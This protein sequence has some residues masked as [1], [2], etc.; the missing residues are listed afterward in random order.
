MRKIFTLLTM[1]CLSIGA[2]WAQIYSP[3]ARTTT[4]EAGKKYFISA[5]TYYRN[6]RPNLLYNNKGNLAYSD[7]KPTGYYK[8]TYV[9][10]VEKIVDGT[11]FIKNSD[12][13]YLQSNSL[14]S[15]VDETGIIVV[16]YGKVKNVHSCG[17]DVDACDENGTFIDYNN[18]DE[19]TPIVCVYHTEKNGW[20]HINGLEI[21]TS[22][23]FAFYEAKEGIQLELTTDVNTPVYYTIKNMRGNAYAAYDGDT[24][25][26]KLLP[27][28]EGPDHLFYFTKGSTEG[29]YKIHTY[30]TDKKCAAYNSWTEDGIDWYI[31]ASGSSNYV[32]FAISKEAT[33]TAKG[34]EAWNDYE[35]AHT[36]INWY[37]GDDD[38][39]VWSIEKHQGVMPGLQ[40]STEGNIVLHYIRSNRRT[41]YVNFD[42]HNVK[43]K[44][45]NEGLNSY[46]YFVE[47]ETAT[48]VPEGYV[49]VKIFNAAHPTAVE[50]YT[51][52]YMEDASRSAKTFL[53]GLRQ[54]KDAYGTGY[55][56]VIYLPGDTK[57]WHD[58]NGTEVGA[59]GLGDRG[60][61]WRIYPANKTVDQLK[62][63]ANTAK[64]NALAFIANAEEADFY[65]YS[66]E[67]IAT[68][69]SAVE[70]MP[71]NKVHDAINVLKTV[72]DPINTLKAEKRS[73]TAPV[74][75]QY[76]LLKNKSKK[77][78]MTTMEDGNQVHRTSD[79]SEFK[80]LW[81]V[82]EG[83]NGVKLYNPAKDL[84]MGPLS[85]SAQVEMVSVE[86]AQEFVFTN[87]AEVYGVF[88]NVDGTQYT[89]AHMD[90]WY[91]RVVGWE[92]VSDASQWII[93][94]VTLEESLADLQEIYDVVD[95]AFGTEPGQ[96]KEMV[97][98]PSDKLSVAWANAKEVLEN[99]E[100]K[101]VYMM[102]ILAYDLK[103][104]WN[105]QLA[106]PDSREINPPVPGKFYRLKNVASGR[107]MNVKDASS[108]V[109]TDAGNNLPSTI[110]Y[111]GD[112]NTMLS[113][114]VGQ[115][116]D[117]QNK[118]LAAVGTPHNGEFAAA[119]S[120][121]KPNT[122]MYKNNSYWTYG[123]CDNNASI[124]RGS[125]KP[126]ANTVGY[127]WTLEKIETLPVTVSSVGVA[128]L[129]TPVAL[130]IP[131]DVNVY[132]AVKD[133]D[134][135][136][137]YLKLQLI[138]TGYI[139]A[140]TGV[141]LE[142]NNADTYYF[143]VTDEPVD[144][145]SSEKNVLTG[146][147]ET[148]YM[149]TDVKVYT[150]QKPTGKDLGFYLFKGTKPITGF[151]SWL[152]LPKDSQVQ[153]FRFKFGTT[154]DIESLVT[155]Q[156]AKAIYDLSGRRVENMDKGIYIVNGK[157]IVVK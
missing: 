57:G 68:A 103:A 13:K 29:T 1:L 85:K 81:Q 141:I 124:N 62:N 88:Q 113:Y 98:S 19:N 75:G 14:A 5:A 132:T 8:S 123:N 61:L 125:N 116:L 100:A 92:A 118:N 51:T 31:I 6:A 67:A 74:A 12:G 48:N 115:Y 47:D 150:L 153:S 37:G 142:A 64:T 109:V 71:I 58:F 28:V 72:N 59:Y 73:T 87:Q 22:T 79:A 42:G 139:P 151:R 60:S 102:S 146:K 83:E 9:F 32:G 30:G 131:A 33:L 120:G 41:T 4:L 144:G 84:Y 157:K 152:E 25:T 77:Q 66:D 89:F 49:A 145:F 134:E 94:E 99:D 112:N 129:Y 130:E 20:R 155:L 45:G 104:K 56:Y 140:N 27:S 121:A 82:V 105:T 117:C 154:T 93:S 35:N 156:N 21:G 111:L 91:D 3:G 101:D 80:A 147:C 106:N 122:I 40:L 135:N 26:M 54:I 70:A 55:G 69:K 119:R 39:S 76:I 18:I 50:D 43:F 11:Y 34:S 114:S 86:D 110:F 127:D 95:N 133:E 107:Y 128:T 46:W 108:V 90:S 38:G 23:P 126:D 15:T 10:T 136:G 97:P 16:P 44:E 2:S 53:V 149:R 143:N 24:E 137:A 36:S 65:T 96:Y 63:E 138:E 52:G 148:S 78:Y 7:N 17:D